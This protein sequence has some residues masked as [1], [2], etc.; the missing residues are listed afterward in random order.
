M[1]P[2]AELLSRDSFSQ[3]LGIKLISVSDANCVTQMKVTKDMLNGFGV[4]HGGVLFSLADSCMV[5]SAIKPDLVQYSIESQISYFKSV[6]LGELLEARSE[7]IHD[8]NRLSRFSICI[9]SIE[10][11]KE[12]ARFYGTVYKL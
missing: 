10:Q 6:A 1:N 12:L 2:A 4:C 3:W 9:Q 7:R 11:K 8:S 5:F